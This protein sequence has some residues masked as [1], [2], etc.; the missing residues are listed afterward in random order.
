MTPAA[1]ERQRMLRA[2]ASNIERICVQ[3]S[4]LRAVC[5]TIFDAVSVPAMSVQCYLVRM[6]RYT[7]FD[8]TVFLV[9]ISYLDR[10][11]QLGVSYC[12][13]IHNIHRLLVTALLVAS[14]ATDDIFHGN[15]FMAQCGGISGKEL[16]KLEYELCRTLKWRLIPS[17]RE[18]QLLR[19]A[20]DAPD[21]GYW[22]VWR[23]TRASPALPPGSSDSDEAQTEPCIGSAC[24]PPARSWSHQIGRVLCG[25]L[26]DAE[27]VLTGNDEPRPITR[28][29]GSG[30][31]E[32]PGSPSSVFHVFRR[33]FS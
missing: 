24:K 9:A 6:R 1:L 8:F 33:I 26:L 15:G 10:L 5:P 14:K 18:L 30:R 31:K 4:D 21:G 23:N 7:K 25:A 3:N 17:L 27:D 32:T 22:E 19:S 20:L 13:T 2:I 29:E 16:N 12:P 28:A 11:C